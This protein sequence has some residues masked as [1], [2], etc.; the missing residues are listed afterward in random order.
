[1]AI[2]RQQAAPYPRS[3][4]NSKNNYY[5]HPTAKFASKKM[6][7]LT[8]EINYKKPHRQGDKNITS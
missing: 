5:I 6:D 2:L 8:H 7:L 3:R 4:I 1:M